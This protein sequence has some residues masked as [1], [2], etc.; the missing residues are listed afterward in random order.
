MKT[1]GILKDLVGSESILVFSAIP[2][3]AQKKYT[4]KQYPVFELQFYFS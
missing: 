4:T 3:I 2:T 1:D